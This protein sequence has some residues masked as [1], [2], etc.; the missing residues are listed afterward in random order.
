MVFVCSVV[1]RNRKLAAV[2]KQ[3]EADTWGG[4]KITQRTD[5]LSASSS[6]SFPRSSGLSPLD[7]KTFFYSDDKYNFLI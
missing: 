4:A 7:P 2:R 5:S 3:K 6:G 1:W